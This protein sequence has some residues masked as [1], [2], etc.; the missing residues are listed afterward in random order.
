MALK[1]AISKAVVAHANVTVHLA[2]R[3]EDLMVC[4]IVAVREGDLTRRD[5]EKIIRDDTTSLRT[6]QGD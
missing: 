1:A 2:E 3:L 6:G 4:V 5:I